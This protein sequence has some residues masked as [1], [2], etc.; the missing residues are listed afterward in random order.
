MLFNSFSVKQLLNELFWAKIRKME[1]RL[2]F[3][4]SLRNMNLLISVQSKFYFYWISWVERN[5]DQNFFL[6]FYRNKKLL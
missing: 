1:K 5:I 3:D 4:K 6:R 2:I